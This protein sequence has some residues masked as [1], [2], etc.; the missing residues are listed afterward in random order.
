MTLEQFKEKLSN[1]PAKITFEDTM[2][3]IENN[4]FFTPTA[5]KNGLLQNKA[6]EN[7]GSCKL[8]SFAIE[9]KFSKNETLA[10]FGTFY[11]KDVLQD[12]SGNNHQNIR[13]FMQTGFSGLVFKSKALQEK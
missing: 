2:S 9:Q 4:Y 11:T 3:V 6:G 1:T 5:F 13:N 12:P 8:F 7:S 10:C